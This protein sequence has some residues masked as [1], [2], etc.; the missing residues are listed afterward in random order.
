MIKSIQFVYTTESG[1]NRKIEK[2]LQRYVVYKHIE[3]LKKKKT[4]YYGHTNVSGITTNRQ[5]TKKTDCIKYGFFLKKNFNHP[6]VKTH[7][8]RT[9]IYL[10]FQGMMRM[11]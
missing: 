8:S 11:V 2:S 4:N 1:K 6:K 7:A 3:I 9:R 10:G 5:K